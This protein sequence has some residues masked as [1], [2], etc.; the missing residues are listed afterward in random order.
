MHHALRDALFS[1]ASWAMFN[2]VREAACFASHPSLRCDV[3]LRGAVTMEALDVAVMWPLQDTYVAAAASTPGGAS[4]AYEAVKFAT[5][6]AELQHSSVTLVPV[7]VDMFGAWG[8]SALPLLS[9]VARAWGSR[10]DMSFS[11]SGPAVF[12][13]LNLTLARRVA[14]MLLINAA[15]DPETALPTT[16]PLPLAAAPSSPPRSPHHHHHPGDAAMDLAAAAAIGDD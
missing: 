15:A 10:T 12:R 9:R 8:A 1:I 13:A 11:R 7:V 5:Y 2:P 14:R 16:Q 3:L 4:T 6:G